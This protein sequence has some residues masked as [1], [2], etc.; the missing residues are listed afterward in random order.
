MRTPPLNNNDTRENP[1]ALRQRQQKK[2]LNNLYGVVAVVMLTVLGLIFIGMKIEQSRQQ[3]PLPANQAC[4][5]ALDM[6]SKAFAGEPVDLA[7]A[8]QACK[9]NQDHTTVSVVAK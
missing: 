5:Q 4:L 6:A 7:G 3:T 2:K 1:R 8:I 9:A